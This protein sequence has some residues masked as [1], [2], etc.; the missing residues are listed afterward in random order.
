MQQSK[1]TLSIP[2]QAII[3]HPVEKEN[4]DESVEDMF[5]DSFLF[6]DVETPVETKAIQDQM[7]Q[8]DFD[9]G[10]IEETEEADKDNI[11]VDGSANL[12]EA[13]SQFDL[14]SPILEEEQKDAAPRRPQC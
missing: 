7:P 3:T 5:G 8:A 6:D 4:L 1:E 2:P 9:F 11:E 13:N 12:L 14:G 10:S